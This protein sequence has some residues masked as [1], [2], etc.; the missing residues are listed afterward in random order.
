MSS[1]VTPL[2]KKI[3]ESGL[4]DS[5][6]AELMEKWQI[7][8]AGASE[9]V[10]EDALK[11]ATREQLLRLAEDIGE[12]AERAD[13]LKETSLSLDSIRWPVT[14]DVV[15]HDRSVILAPAVGA[16]VDRFDRY[17]FRPEPGVMEHLVPGNQLDRTTGP[18]SDSMLGQIA[19][20]T[21]LYAGQTLV[22]IQVS[23][24]K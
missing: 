8:P 1:D 11:D 6:M 17:Y 14:V 13:K 12:E 20:A 23:V 21:P 5:H 4:V 24:V 15:R 2:T 16:V 18:V 10:R 3:L 19:E 7:I 9:L 22:C